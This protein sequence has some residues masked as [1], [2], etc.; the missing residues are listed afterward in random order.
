MSEPT[1]TVTARL[2]FSKSNHSF[3]RSEGR[4]PPKIKWIAV[5]FLGASY[6]QIPDTQRHTGASQQTPTNRA[7]GF[8]YAGFLKKKGAVSVI[9]ITKSSGFCKC[10]ASVT[11][12]FARY[13]SQRDGEI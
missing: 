9:G 3:S 8:N 13:I 10:N 5:L 6:S 1:A 4:L 12:R 11:F 2:F 7:G